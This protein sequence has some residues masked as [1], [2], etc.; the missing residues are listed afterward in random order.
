MRPA[1]DSRAMRDLGFSPRPVE[2]TIV[3]TVRPLATAGRLGRGAGRLGSTAAAAAPAPETAGY[4]R[5][6]RRQRR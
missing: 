4:T 5:A 1:D 3:D 6:R 2:E